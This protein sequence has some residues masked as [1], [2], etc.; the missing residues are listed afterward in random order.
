MHDVTKLGIHYLMIFR[1]YFYLS[2]F[3]ALHFM[4]ILAC[5]FRIVHD[6]GALGVARKIQ[7]IVWTRIFHICPH[8]MVR[9][10]FLS[11]IVFYKISE[12][13]LI[14]IFLREIK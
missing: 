12:S 1:F 13:P 4:S 9:L 11:E 5:I 14:I 8:S 7:V 6:L 10:A 2:L 3:C